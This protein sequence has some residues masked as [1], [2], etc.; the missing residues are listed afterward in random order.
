MDAR[1][2][3]FL[4]LLPAMGAVLLVLA[5]ALLA[6]ALA[7][8]IMLVVPPAGLAVLALAA[9]SSVALLSCAALWWALWGAAPPAFQRWCSMM[10]MA[11]LLGCGVAL[12]FLISMT[13]SALSLPQPLPGSTNR[14]AMLATFEALLGYLVLAPALVFVWRRADGLNR[15][16]PMATALSSV[17]LAWAASAGLAVATAP[18]LTQTLAAQRERQAAVIDAGTAEP[19]AVALCKGDLRQAAAELARPGARP[20]GATIARRCTA[21]DLKGGGGRVFFP[22]RVELALQAIV[23]AER[24]AGVDPA[25]GCTPWQRDLLRTLYRSDARRLAQ[26]A[27][28]GL[29][30]DCPVGRE[31]EDA[32]PLWWGIFKHLDAQSPLPLEGLQTMDRLGVAWQRRAHDGKRWLD[33]SVDWLALGHVPNASLVHLLE[34]TGSTDASPGVVAAV[35]MA[36]L[37]NGLTADER[38]R[39]DAL[40]ERIGEPT[41]E[42]IVALYRTRIELP[43]LLDH[44]LNQRAALTYVLSK[45]V[46]YAVPGDASAEGINADRRRLFSELELA[47]RR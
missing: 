4:A 17:V 8:V 21:N 44:R 38:R 40:A 6:L 35:A 19:V 15:P 7:G 12:F 22:E 20:D 33:H 41:R 43:P 23:L 45:V 9:A 1:R 5:T 36:R 3:V 16:V 18:L 13:G 47:T 29:P 26:F 28:L 10:R 11:A 27:A 25:T 46:P 31:G 24:Q 14:W 32:R 30:I 39:L 2:V 34:R 37:R 42:Q